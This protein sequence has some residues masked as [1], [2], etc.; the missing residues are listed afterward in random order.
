MKSLQGIILITLALALG[1]C[2]W[3]RSDDPGYEESHAT[4]GNLSRS[5]QG[6]PPFYEVYGKRYSVMKSSGGYRERGT[7]SWY[8]K[9]FHGR[10]TSSGERYDMHKMTAAHKTLPLPTNVRVTNLANGRSIVVRVN[11]RGPFVKNRLIDLSYAAARKLDIIANGTGYVEVVALTGTAGVDK[12]TRARATPAQP[13]SAPKSGER[14]YVQFGAF[15]DRSKALA[16]ANRLSSGGLNKVRVHESRN[17]S[18]KLYRVRIGPISSTIEYDRIVRAAA[19]LL[20]TET[21]LV[22]DPG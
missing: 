5:K 3:S 18:P 11:D 8:G 7:A 12:P 16:M 21:H 4:S 14:M 17:N 13:V 20:I 1:S 6:N 9:K 10:S 22:T 15:G 19:R 2:S